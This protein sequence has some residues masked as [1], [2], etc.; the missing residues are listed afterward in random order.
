M[1]LPSAI[2]SEDPVLYFPSATGIFF[3][4]KGTVQ[5]FEYRHFQGMVLRVPLGSSEK[6]NS[7][8]DYISKA[9]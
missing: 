3:F 4:F 7:T 2:T 9:L 8:Q 1:Q 5:R 6:Q